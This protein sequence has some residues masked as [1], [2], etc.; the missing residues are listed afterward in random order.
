[1]SWLR[2]KDLPSITAGGGS[3][4]KIVRE[5]VAPPRHAACTVRPLKSGFRGEPRHVLR[6]SSIQPDGEL[7][8]LRPARI[9]TDA[10]VRGP[11]LLVL[12]PGRY[13]ATASE[14]CTIQRPSAPHG[15]AAVTFCTLER[16]RRRAS[17]G[18]STAGRVAFGAIAQTGARARSLD[19]GHPLGSAHHW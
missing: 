3:A 9:R 14:P 15:A 8:T 1:M 13:S 19:P 10:D 4:G 11:D 18:S 2:S 5:R 7:P 16:L 12:R 17:A 6:H